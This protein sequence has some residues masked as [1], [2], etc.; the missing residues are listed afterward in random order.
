M[1]GKLYGENSNMLKTFGSIS[2]R[3]SFAID[4]RVDFD[5]LTSSPGLFPA[6]M[7]IPRPSLC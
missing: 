5:S 1:G 7:T 4:P 2:K 3:V 6:P